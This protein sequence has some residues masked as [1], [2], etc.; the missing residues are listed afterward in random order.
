MA[1]CKNLKKLISI[2]VIIAFFFQ[3]EIFL[4]PQGGGDI[5]KQFQKAKIEY[6]NGQYV[7]SRNRLER[8]IG[9][10][11]GKGLDN[12]NILGKCYLLLGA[13]YEKEE[14]I[15]LAEEN[16]R[17]AIAD[18]S[19]DAIDGVGFKELTIYKRVKETLR[20]ENEFEKAIDEYINGQYVSAKVGL[21]AIANVVN[22]KDLDR[23]DILGKCYLLLGAIYEKEENARLAE[24]NYR[25]AI[26]DYVI[27]SVEGVDFTE[28]IIYK[29]MKK[30]IR[31]ENEFEK[32]K[33][34]Y[35]TGQYTN[36]KSRVE[37]IINEIDDEKD[38][39]GKDILGKCYL[40]LGA[41]YEKDDK[42]RIAEE[43]Y[44]KAKEEYG[45]QSIEGLDLENLTIYK[46]VVKKRIIEK[47]AKPKR[48]K[49]KF[50]VLLVVGGIVV[51][52]VLVYLLTK[53]KKEGEKNRY[54][55]TVTRGEGVDGTPNSGTTTYDEGSIVNYNYS[56]QSGYSNL[57]V[58]LDGTEVSAIGT[59]TMDRNHT[60]EATAGANV[61]NFV[62][63]VDQI[64]ISEGSTATFNVRL[65]A[66]PTGNVDVTVSR[67][68][69]DSDIT[70]LSGSNLTYGPSNWNVD[71]SITLQAGEDD[72]MINGQAAI[73][74]SASG[75][76]QKNITVIEQDNDSVDRRPSVSITNPSNGA[77]VSG[78]VL[79][80]A[81]A[82]DDIG[83]RRVEFYK[84]GKFEDSDNSYPYNY[85]W[86][87][88]DDSNAVHFIRVVAYDTAN[89]SA[90]DEIMV[91]VNN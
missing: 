66:Q 16:Y 77:T 18:Y 53:K 67:E 35:N 68:S 10:I 28:L 44:R 43:N 38:L 65:S 89:Q 51:V 49:R 33:N 1:Y 82:S 58:R 69:G 83:I 27:D 2:V 45:I 85:N 12:K 81:D 21:E 3:C 4:Y 73:A 7:N 60:L 47:E 40:L 91:T 54:T 26:G 78:N 63:D 71:Q 55:L 37:K 8:I 59:I 9:T 76:S 52:A 22:E 24:E 79:I 48:K 31:I 64:E 57:V 56:L 75:I 90:E 25:K 72:D 74:I 41:I 6:N 42:T 88:T 23:K 19:I 14:K 46:R 13:I 62:T 29:K 30:T 61:V 70:V 87:T 20:I 36:S 17:K 84:D 39:D 86:T 34:D 11:K 50:P 80:Q 32:S 15:L 5:V